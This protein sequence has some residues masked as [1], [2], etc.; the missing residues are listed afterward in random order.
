[1]GRGK[2]VNPKRI[3][4]KLREIRIKLDLTQEAMFNALADQ[5][6]NIHP[7]YISLYEIGQNMS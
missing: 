3:A 4:E 7:G 2:Q 5:G 6:A 1:M